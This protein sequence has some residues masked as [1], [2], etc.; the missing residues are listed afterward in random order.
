M[1]IFSVKTEFA[2]YTAVHKSQVTQFISLVNVGVL[3]VGGRDSELEFRPE[4][5]SNGYSP[6]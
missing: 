6:A 1:G 2:N 3:V 4:T 5:Y